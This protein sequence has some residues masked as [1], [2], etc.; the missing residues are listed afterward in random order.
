[1]KSIKKLAALVLAGVLTLSIFTGCGVDANKTAA[2]L[3]EQKVSLGLVNFMARYQKASV[4]DM[5][6]AYFGNGVWDMDMSGDGTTLQESLLTN[7]MSELHDLYTIKANMGEYKVTLTADE[8]SEYIRIMGTVVTFVSEKSC[9]FIIGAESF[10]NYDAF[11]EEIKAMGA[12]D[13]LKIYDGA[14]KR[15]NSR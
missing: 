15:Y 2:T 10:D 8:E 9:D 6:T 1:M 5:Y 7:I 4:D 3:G 13:A 11:V 14:L 12:E